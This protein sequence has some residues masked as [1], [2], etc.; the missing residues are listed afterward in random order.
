[1]TISS[2]A[3]FAEEECIFDQ[4]QQKLDYLELEKQYPGSKYIENE[5]K[6]IIPRENH[7][8]HF[9]KGGCV[10][11]GITIES[12]Q[13]ITEKY[14]NENSLFLEVVSLIEEYGQGMVDSNKLKTLLNQKKWNNLSNDD[15][16]YYFVP[17]EGYTAFE[18]YQRD[19][20]SQT[21]IG[22]SFYD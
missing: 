14:K 2:F 17:Y 19:E 15:V 16:M 11:Y 20:D 4:N 21:I 18:I 1:M 6:L 8:I 9:R 12:I 5:Y 13:P 22:V 7:Q 10:H 3:V